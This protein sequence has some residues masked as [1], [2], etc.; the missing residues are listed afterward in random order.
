VLRIRWLRRGGG[1]STATPLRIYR[2]FRR[3]II[4]QTT[5]QSD[6]GGSPPSGRRRMTATRCGDAAYWRRGGCMAHAIPQLGSSRG[7]LLVGRPT[8]AGVV[9]A[10]GKRAPWRVAAGHGENRNRISKAARPANCIAGGC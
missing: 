8:E 3:P 5:W 6:V 4:D 9:G 7:A 1:I 10:G 2:A